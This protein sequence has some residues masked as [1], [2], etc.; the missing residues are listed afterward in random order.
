MVMLG[1]AVLDE[2]PLG[3]FVEDVDP[4]K[5]DID[6]GM[7]LL[8][9]SFVIDDDGDDELELETVFEGSMPTQYA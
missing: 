7:A 8:P 5:D 2:L 9:L 4:L 3:D 6:V 1:L